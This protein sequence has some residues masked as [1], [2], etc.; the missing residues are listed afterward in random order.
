M[1]LLEPCPQRVSV[2]VRHGHTSGEQTFDFDAVLDRLEIRHGRA[3]H[4]DVI[5]FSA[6]PR[7]MSAPT[8]ARRRPQVQACPKASRRAY[9]ADRVCHRETRFVRDED[10]LLVAVAV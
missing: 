6:Q 9:L 4:D 10:L 7:L 8:P 3:R 1:R 5:L 2:F